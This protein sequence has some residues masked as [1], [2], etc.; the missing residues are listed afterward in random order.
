MTCPIAE[1][2]KRARKNAHL[3]QR[4][5]ESHT[6][7]GNKSISRYEC[8]ASAPEPDTI[9]TLLRLYDVSAAYILGLSDRP[10][11][12][13]QDAAAASA[14]SGSLSAAEQRLLAA[15]R[16]A[17]P[18]RRAQAEQLLGLPAEVPPAPR[19]ILVAAQGGGVS[20]HVITAS[21]EQIRQAMDE[22]ESNFD[23]Y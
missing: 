1:R 11:R 22:D 21:D 16:G 19:T 18:E 20:S 3:T 8:G 15:Y 5:V 17:A 12:F 13:D 10:G 4:D 9:V 7:I 14:A 23:D 6:G 2:L